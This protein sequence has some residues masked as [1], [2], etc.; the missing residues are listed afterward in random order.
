MRGRA[1]ATVLGLVVLA[2]PRV[3][4][5][6]VQTS[7]PVASSPRLAFVEP[8]AG[9]G[10]PL[11]WLG[12]S[13]VLRPLDRLAT[14]VGAGLGTQGVQLSAGARTSIPVGRRAIGL[15][16][17]WSTG[18]Y[19]GVDDGAYVIGAAQPRIYRWDRAQLV[20]VELS[21]EDLASR[22]SRLSV[23]PFVGLGFV[24]NGSDGVC[25]TGASDR[26]C[27]GPGRARFVPFAGIAV[28]IGVL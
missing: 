16:L 8:T 1:T 11:G 4:A 7:V 17:A 26:Q 14:H 19:A 6:E 18:S 3:H 20:N 24:L 9:F 2:S 25:A 15:G 23:R 13:L 22:E 12:A 10:T 28:P 5:D 21:I 27:D